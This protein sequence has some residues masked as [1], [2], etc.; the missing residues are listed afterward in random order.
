MTDN[1]KQAV[2]KLLQFTSRTDR[3][4]AVTFNDLAPLL[5]D[6]ATALIDLDRRLKAKED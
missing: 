1:I 4:S 5:S 6:I 2:E 3:A